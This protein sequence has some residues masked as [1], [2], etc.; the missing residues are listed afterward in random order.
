MLLLEETGNVTHLNILLL[1]SAHVGKTSLRRVFLRGSHSSGLGKTRHRGPWLSGY[2]P[3]IEDCNVIQYILPVAS[4]TGGSLSGSAL[5]ISPVESLGSGSTISNEGDDA[6][7]EVEMTEED[8]WQKR[9]GQRIVLTLSDVG[10]HPFYGTIWASAIAAADAFILIYDVGNRQS[11]EAIFG[12]YRQIMEVKCARPATLPIMLLGNMV[13]NVTSDPTR[14][15]PDKR[16]RQVTKDMGQ[17][18]ADL[19][20]VTF[21]ETTVMAPQSVAHCFRQ[22]LIS[23]QEHARALLASGIVSLANEGKMGHAYKSRRNGSTGSL[24]SNDSGGHRHSNQSHRSA[25]ASTDRVYGQVS[26]TQDME[27]N[28]GRLSAAGNRDSSNTILSEGSAIS[29]TKPSGP[30]TVVNPTLKS[31]ASSTLSTRSKTVVDA[32]KGLGPAKADSIRFRRDMVF[33]AWRTFQRGGTVNVTGAQPRSAGVSREVLRSL[34]T[35]SGGSETFG[36][37]ISERAAS[38]IRLS[39]GRQHVQSQLS[40]DSSASIPASQTISIASSTSS[41]EIA[42]TSSTRACVEEIPRAPQTHTLSLYP[43][44]PTMSSVSSDST[45]PYALSRKQTDVSMESGIDVN[46]LEHIAARHQPTR[47]PNLRAEHRTISFSSDVAQS[48]GQEERKATPPGSPALSRVEGSAAASP[49]T[50]KQRTLRLQKSQRDLQQLLDDLEGFNFEGDESDDQ[51]TQPPVAPESSNQD[52]FRVPNSAQFGSTRSHAPG[53]LRIEVSA[54]HV[55][56]ASDDDLLSP[57]GDDIELPPDVQSEPWEDIEQERYH[58]SSLP[59]PAP[60]RPLQAPKHLGQHANRSI[61]SGTA[62]RENVNDT[63]KA[64]A[65]MELL[66]GILAELDE[67][68]MRKIVDEIAASKQKRQ[69]SSNSND[70]RHHQHD[71]REPR[72]GDGDLPVIPNVPGGL[73]G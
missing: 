12:F 2:D 40:M 72:D 34:L 50:G 55:A 58:D 68:D 54:P 10:G 61:S 25:T 53:A 21:N 33:R 5:P 20:K 31:I 22:I 13:D 24:Q 42:S 14:S 30:L 57:P 11:F 6:D 19:L 73:V 38:S 26:R 7:K 9:R 63:L 69:G 51:K 23:A 18:L 52:P 15:A 70:H 49:A 27:A 64:Q 1:G 45:I 37:S 67:T 43:T 28:R 4:P 41:P 48:V 60:R 59:P 35:R 44:I 47:R 17:A 32:N 16:P 71:A 36:S 56:S 62:T 3:T 65:N 39:A 29:V 66:R 8:L 46:E